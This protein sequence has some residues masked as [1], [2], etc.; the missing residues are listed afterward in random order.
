[1]NFQT[2]QRWPIKEPNNVPH[3]QANAFV[4]KK[5]ATIV[6][7]IPNVYEFNVHGLIAY[8]LTVWILEL[9]I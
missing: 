3:L 4:V 7:I 6:T 8:K 9:T 5:S 2:K 1:M